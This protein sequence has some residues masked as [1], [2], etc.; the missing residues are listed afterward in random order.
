MAK[1]CNKKRKIFF[2]DRG[3]R[4]FTLLEIMIAIAIMVGAIL[5]ILGLF[6]NFLVLVETAKN[7]TVAVDNAQAVLEEIRNTDPFTVNNV[8][9]A[10]PAGVNL[11]PNFSFDKLDNEAIY[12]SYGSLAADPLQITVTVN[13]QEKTRSRS[14]S[15]ITKMS[16]R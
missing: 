6:L 5:A 16:Q 10:F 13:W 2:S 7:T 12:V 3:T 14:E 11:A 9:A 4:G 15:L 1:F 8:T